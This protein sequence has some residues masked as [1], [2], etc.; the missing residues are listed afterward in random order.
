MTIERKLPNGRVVKFPANTSEDVIGATMRRLTNSKQDVNWTTEQVRAVVSEITA[1]NA[2]AV[3][4]KNKIDNFG[5]AI[6]KLASVITKS[7]TDIVSETKKINEK[8]NQDF[9]KAFET[10][11]GQ[12][13]EKVLKSSPNYAKNIDQITGTI[14]KDLSK[15]IAL[16]AS[17]I[18]LSS[19]SLNESIGTMTKALNAN[20][21]LLAK[22]LNAQ[23]QNS[24]NMSEMIKVLSAEKII[25]RDKDGNMLSVK[26]KE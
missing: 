5:P 24:N 26:I 18:E 8:T 9:L 11:M 23:L 25:N 12:T 6:E 1:K 21:Q 16:V 4:D 3:L 22:V 13:V 14:T 7:A 2:E 17:G 15:Q 10:S 19:Q 20:T